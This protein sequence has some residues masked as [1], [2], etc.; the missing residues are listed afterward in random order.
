MLRGSERL[1]EQ[2]IYLFRR[3]KV[4]IGVEDIVNRE[5]QYT[6]YYDL[7]IGMITVDPLVVEFGNGVVVVGL[8][9][10]VVIL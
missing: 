3:T 10:D 4:P 8:E 1:E 2:K 7:W 5:S 6:F 9:V